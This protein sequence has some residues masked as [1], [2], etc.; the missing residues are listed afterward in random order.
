VLVHEGK[1]Y[2]ITKRENI[3]DLLRNQIILDN[4]KFS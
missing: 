4:V 3:D 1:D 2:L